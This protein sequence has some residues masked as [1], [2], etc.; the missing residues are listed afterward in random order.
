[1]R[2]RSEQ[3]I[4][5]RQAQRQPRGAVV[6]AVQRVTAYLGAATHK[7]RA[8]S[9]INDIAASVLDLA[10]VP[11]V[12]DASVERRQPKGPGSLKSRLGLAH[13]FGRQS[14][15]Q[16]MGASQPQSCWQVNGELIAERFRCPCET[17]S[18]FLVL[19]LAERRLGGFFGGRLGV[20]W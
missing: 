6:A 4:R 16:V 19:D 1:F 11:V 2:Q 9:N 3:C 17:R 10:L 12:L 14:D 7:E 20:C 15:L 18:L 13:P 5:K 8:A